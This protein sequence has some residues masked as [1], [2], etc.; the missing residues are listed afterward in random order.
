MS[1]I[2]ILNEKSIGHL[3]SKAK[4]IALSQSL[5]QAAALNTVATEIGFSCWKDVIKT[6]KFESSGSVKIVFD[7]TDSDLYSK[8]LDHCNSDKKP[9]IHEVRKHYSSLISDEYTDLQKIGAIARSLGINPSSITN[10]IHILLEPDPEI[11]EVR[12]S[13]WETIGLYRDEIFSTKIQAEDPFFYE[14]DTYFVFRLI[15]IDTQSYEE[16]YDYLSRIKGSVGN[17]I[18]H[19][20]QHVWINGKIEYQA[21][22]L[23]AWGDEDNDFVLEV[24]EDEPLPIPELSEHIWKRAY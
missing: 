2:H 15:G 13:E 20:I 22:P 1:N 16:V 9:T 12:D 18:A 19:A 21:P 8:F 14:A 10:T 7:R 17:A 24:D 4:K 11:V 3:K 5:S 6:L 23:F